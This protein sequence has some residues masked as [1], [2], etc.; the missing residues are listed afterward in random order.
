MKR[1][2]FAI[3]GVGLGFVL[4]AAAG[5]HGAVGVRYDV[6]VYY[7]TYCAPAPPPPPV[8]VGVYYGPVWP[9]YYYGY[10]IYGGYCGPSVRVGGWYGGHWR[11]R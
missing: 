11:C 9:R 10:R 1:I 4:L 2:L 6:P 5:C 3:L 8:S 7:G